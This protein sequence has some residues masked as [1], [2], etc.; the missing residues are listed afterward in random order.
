MMSYAWVVVN[1]DAS[2]ADGNSSCR[3]TS[4]YCSFVIR[5]CLLIYHGE[6]PLWDDCLPVLFFLRALLALGIMLQWNAMLLLRRRQILCLWKQSLIMIE[7]RL[8]F[9]FLNMKIE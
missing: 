8:N 3:L 7:V 9:H 4:D 5:P 6:E 2:G 1:V